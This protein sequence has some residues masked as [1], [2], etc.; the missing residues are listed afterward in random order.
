MKHTAVDGVA[1][2]VIVI[3]IIKKNADHQ[4]LHNVNRKIFFALL[5]KHIAAFKVK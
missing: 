4:Q 1:S 5:R 3:I 2:S